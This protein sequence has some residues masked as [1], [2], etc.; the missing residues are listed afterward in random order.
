MFLQKKRK[1]GATPLY[2]YIYIENLYRKI[3]SLHKRYLSIRQYQTN[4]KKLLYGRG[5]WYEVKR[6]LSNL[7]G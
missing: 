5:F 7:S 2:L 6:D 1:F 4:I 3:S